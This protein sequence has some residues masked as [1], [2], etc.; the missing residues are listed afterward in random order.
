MDSRQDLM[1]NIALQLKGLG[2]HNTSSRGTT[3]GE[4]SSKIVDFVSP[5]FVVEDDVV[6]GS[7]VSLKI[8]VM[9]KLHKVSSRMWVVANTCIMKALMARQ[10]LSYTKMIEL[11]WHVDSPGPQHCCLTRNTANARQWWAS[12]GGLRSPIYQQSCCE[13]ESR[14]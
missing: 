7:G 4:P 13:M 6:F 11:N 14:G 8:N 5:S 12:C 1:D 2:I 3:Q 9:P 10:Y